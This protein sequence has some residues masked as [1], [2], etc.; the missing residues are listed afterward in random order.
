VPKSLHFRLVSHSAASE[1]SLQDFVIAWLERA[2]PLTPA[3]SSERQMAL[4][5]APGPRPA[6][7]R[8]EAHSLADGPGAARGQQD[9][10]PC[11]R[12]APSPLGVS[13]EAV[14]P[15]AAPSPKAPARSSRDQT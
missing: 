5:P 15:S 13:S 2:T 1:M 8:Q 11:Q 4:E 10:A 3:P 7:D 12:L 14:G 9:L 6:Q